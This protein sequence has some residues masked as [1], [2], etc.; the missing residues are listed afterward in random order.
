M[1]VFISWSGPATKAFATFLREWLPLVIQSV[2][3]WMS[4]SDV[5]KGSRSMPE[6]GKELEGT[7]FGIVVL[8]AANQTSQ[9]INFEAGAISKGVGDSRVIPLLLDLTKS[10]VVGPLSQFQ[11]VDAADRAEV[12]QLLE[13]LNK[14]LPDP[15]PDQA[16]A[17]V[18][19]REW[20]AFS[21]E[22]ARF[23]EQHETDE[24]VSARGDR[25]VLDEVLVTVRQI[26]HDLSSQLGRRT[27][28]QPA[29]ASYFDDA[30]LRAVQDVDFL[31][32]HDA[33]SRQVLV[34]RLEQL[35]KD[36]YE[37]EGK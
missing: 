20:S 32:T 11:A 2:K 28:S 21:D 31:R 15:L 8:T 30:L 36:N 12:K 10:D 14:A 3:P 26:S 33:D 34:H 6:L 5:T 9:W 37:P 17:H 18:F 19:A 1:K 27:S 24:R 13:A 22:L 29:R 23:R 16:L 4:D 35:F 25:E 7:S